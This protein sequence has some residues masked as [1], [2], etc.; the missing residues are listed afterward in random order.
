[1]H[2]VQLDSQ[3]Y[4]QA[5]RRATEAGFKSVDEYVADLLRLDLEDGEKLDHLFT[6]ERLAHID[7]AAA[8]IDAG[9][10]IP[11]EQVREHLAKRRDE[12]LRQK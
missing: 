12:W 9:L 2:H 7:R 4:Q 3:L 6:P 10:G 11:A 1:M 8:Q 5:Q